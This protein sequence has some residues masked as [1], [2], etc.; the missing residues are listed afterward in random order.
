MTEVQTDPVAGEI[1]RAAIEVHHT[2]GPGLLESTYQ[3][4]LGYEFVQM[5]MRFEQQ[6][7]VP[8]IYKGVKLDCGYR[9]DLLVDGDIIVEVKSVEKVL[10][11]HTAQVLTYLRL[12]RARQALLNFNCLTL[13]EGLKSHLRSGNL[14]P[15][16][17]P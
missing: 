6:V 9:L 13:K 15:L 8:V 4:C 12:T 3:S 11:I 2:L 5:G 16:Q 10:P 7:P 17:S 1:I 14:V